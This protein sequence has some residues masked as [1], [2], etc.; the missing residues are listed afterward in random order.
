MGD[1]ARSKGLKV[2]GLKVEGLKVEGLKVEGRKSEEEEEQEEQEEQEEERSA[3]LSSLRSSMLKV[4]CSMFEE[5]V[6]ISLIF[7]FA[8]DGGLCSFLRLCRFCLRIHHVLMKT[9]CKE[10]R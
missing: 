2:E 8:W 4:R 6:W 9:T 5:L 3:F 7:R 10:K 1:A